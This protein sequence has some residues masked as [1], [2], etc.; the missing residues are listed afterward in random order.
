MATRPFGRLL[1]PHDIALA[2]AYFASDDSALVTGTVMD[3]E[4]YP[5]RRAAELVARMPP[6]DQPSFPSATSTSSSTAACLRGLDPRGA[7]RSAAKA[8]S[9][10]TASSAASTPSRRRSDRRACWTRPAS[11]R[12]CCASRPTSPTP[13]RTSGARQV[14]RQKAAIDLTVRLGAPHLPDAQRAALS[15]HDA[16]RRGSRARSRACRRSLDYA[17]RRGVVLCME[18]H[19]K[20]GT[21]RYPE[22]AQPED[23]FLEILER[24]DSPSLRRRST[25]RRTRPSAATIRLRFLEKVKHRVVSMHASDRYLAPGATLDDLRA[26]DGAAGYAATLRHGETG[27]GLQRLRRDLPAS[28]PRSASTAGSRSRTA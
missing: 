7:R 17:E 13:T 21:W 16:R 24:I 4:Q 28:S 8:S 27:T 5:D 2:A 22:F 20:D 15:G 19:Y 25:T 14:E 1:S 26:A 9:T 23:I 10:T 11:R 6:R 12:R 18:N 3:L